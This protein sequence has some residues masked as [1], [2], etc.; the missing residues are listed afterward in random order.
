MFLPGSKYLDS[1]L[2]RSGSSF[3]FAG[4][5]SGVIPARLL[6]HGG[7]WT[8]STDPNN[9]LQGRVKGVRGVAGTGGGNARDG[10]RVHKRRSPA[11]AAVAVP[12]RRA[13]LAAAA[14]CVRAL[15]GVTGA[16]L[17][18]VGAEQGQRALGADERVVGVAAAVRTGR[19][20]GVGTRGGEA[21]A[22]L[23]EGPAHDVCTSSAP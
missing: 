21:G 20:R 6:S 9:A 17:D 2:P 15:A 14:V 3:C 8:V 5:E 11:F 18:A 19:A 22:V 7:R 13:S 10:W 23:V 1:F 4:G 12:P 16:A